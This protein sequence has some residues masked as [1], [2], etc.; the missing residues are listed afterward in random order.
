MV[1]MAMAIPIAMATLMVATMV[2]TMAVMAAGAAMET[3]P[4]RMRA[5][6]SEFYK[7]VM[8]P[9]HMI[10]KKAHRHALSCIL[11]AATA[12]PRAGTQTHPTT[13]SYS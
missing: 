8:I 12:A 6:G 11:S 5:V 9:P 1:A 13:S 7:P 2:A 3:T 4:T 10:T